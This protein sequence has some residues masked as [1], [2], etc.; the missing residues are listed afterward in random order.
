VKIHQI[1]PNFS[2]GDAIGDDTIALQ[3]ILR[4]LGHESRIF[5]GVIHQKLVDQAR[6]WGKYKEISDPNNV[7]IYHFSVGSEITKMLMT[8]P[9][10]LVIVFHNITPSHW[11]F[12]TSPH[13]TELAAG[14]MAQLKALKDRVEIAWADS[15]F[16]AEILRKIGY[17]SVR[18]LPIIVDF[19]KHSVPPDRIFLR[20]MA[21][22][23]KTWLFVGRV[24]PNKCHQDIIRAFGFYKKHLEP[25]SR[26]ILVGD[27]RNCHR[28]SDAMR[29]LVSDLGIR[30]VL[31]TGMIDDDEL[32]ALYSMADVFI[33]M[34]EH[35]G[36]C[37][38]V[39]EAMRF[40]VPVV[41]YAAGAVPDTMDGAGILVHRK[42]PL[43]TAEIVHQ[44]LT[45]PD[46]RN[47]LIV[48]QKMRFDRFINTDMKLKVAELLRELV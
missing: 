33:C 20:Q 13:M 18:V 28:Y 22:T 19:K 39:L 10:R 11:F 7:L 1:L 2:Y 16:N 9:D 25:H 37:V 14:G 21:S 36:F 47:K 44:C 5:A 6:H 12:G 43:T 40:G 35:E 41:A 24:S 42:D 26:L 17:K 8:C 29:D 4:D 27:V 32:V 45:D 34:S 30:D 15:E 46:L 3:K 38:P 31:F 48:N 23:H